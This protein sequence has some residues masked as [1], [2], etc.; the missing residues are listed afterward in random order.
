MPRRA[1]PDFIAMRLPHDQPQGA[2]ARALQVVQT[3]G[4]VGFDLERHSGLEFECKQ[5]LAERIDQETGATF[6]GVNVKYSLIGVRSHN[7]RVFLGIRIQTDQYIHRIAEGVSAAGVGDDQTDCVLTGGGKVVRGVLRGAIAAITE[8]P[9]PRLRLVLTQIIEYNRIGVGDGAEIGER[10]GK[11][12]DDERSR[13]CRIATG[14]GSGDRNGSSAVAS[15]RNDGI[16]GA[17][18]GPSARQGPSVR[19]RIGIV[20]DRK[21]NGASGTNGVRTGDR[22]G[23]SRGGRGSDSKYLR[24][25][26]A[27]SIVDDDGDIAAISIGSD[28]DAVGGTAARPSAW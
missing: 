7:E 28:R 8:I 27:T 3:C 15:R 9:C 2:S 11:N 20:G 21:R 18:S 26:S 13:G 5:T 17:A 1:P 12:G 22:T 19:G 10:C 16:V 23:G 24:S 25:R 14:I 6:I 4:Q